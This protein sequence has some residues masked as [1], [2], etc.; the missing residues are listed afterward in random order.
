VLALV[1]VAWLPV[2]AGVLMALYLHRVLRSDYDLPL[3]VMNQFLSSWVHLLMLLGPVLLAWRFV[4]MPSGE[5]DESEIAE[6][7][8]QPAAAVKRPRY[9]AAVALVL[10]AGAIFTVAVQWDPV[11]ERQA[12]R[13]MVVERH[14]TWE[15]TTRPYDTQWFGHDSGYNYAAVYRY[16]SQFFEMSR[17]LPSD[18]ID[19]K[20]L[21]NCDVLV[22]KTPTERY[23]KDEVE[24]ILQF[25]E[26][27]GGLLLVGD[28][29]NV[30]NCGTYLNDIARPMGFVFRHDL[31]FGTGDSPYDQLYCPPL[32]PHP[33]VEHLPPTNLAVSCSI[34]PGRS[35]GRAA[36]RATGLW[37]LPP[38]YH[39]ENY[40]PFPE[41]R[42]E[43]RYGAFIELWTTRYGAGRVAAFGDSTIF[44]N[45]CVFQPGK[46]E[47]MRDMVE[48][49]N[50]R[51]MGAPG[52]WLFGLG[53]LPLA[54]G[55]WLAYGRH[56]TDARSKGTPTQSTA[57]PG[58]WLVLLA[59]GTCGWAVASIATAAAGRSAMPVP[60]T[61]RPSTRVVIDRTTSEVPLCKG[62]FI[63]G[64]GEGY[65]LFEQWIP[66]LG[67]Y[68]TRRTG[69]EAFSGDALVVICPNR[70]VSAQFREGLIRYV[71]DGG[72]LLVID[73]PENTASTANSLLWPFG[74]SVLHDQAFKGKLRL[75]GQWPDVDV[76]RAWPISGGQ[77]VAWLGETPIGAAAEYGKGLVMAIGFGSVLNDAAMKRTWDIEPDE[78]L[79]TRYDVLF[80]LVRGL[81]EDQPIEAPLKQPEHPN[82]SAATDGRSRKQ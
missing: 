51:G 5:L 35:R 58:T 80:A 10:L 49:L 25:V 40:H 19:D 54:A 59:A 1:V 65:G 72:R 16:L 23:Q 53:L 31:L 75:A 8:D 13:V 42:P 43:M 52:P 69:D 28:H 27:G 64:D 21:S 30:F 15:P 29:T 82:A 33:I 79:R 11:G 22:I 61:L 63:E 48:W 73:S 6:Q 46:A 7:P 24:A 4:P 38:E 14:S 81:V 67:Y 36:M 77:P 39:S 66:R 60:E 78:A 17:L 68:T 32:V 26:R 3:H 74:L 50:H 55:L 34:D 47:L 71:A 45:F 9:L 70:P 18:R 57:G 2:R 62:A 20:T 37:N 56:R 76:Q 44:S 41:H 12:G